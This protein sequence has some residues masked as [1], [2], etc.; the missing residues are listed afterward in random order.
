[1][2]SSHIYHPYCAR[3]NKIIGKSYEVSP[4]LNE[5]KSKFDKEHYPYVTHIPP[6]PPDLYQSPLSLLFSSL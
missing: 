5:T 4:N 2:G 6:H 1:M 3:V